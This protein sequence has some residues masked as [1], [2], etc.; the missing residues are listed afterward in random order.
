MGDPVFVRRMNRMVTP[1]KRPAW[2]KRALN[3][4]TPTTDARE[5]VRTTSVELDG[6]EALFPTVRMV[7]GK[8]KKYEGQE[9]RKEAFNIAMKKKDF[10]F[11]NTILFFIVPR[12][13]NKIDIIDTTSDTQR[14]NI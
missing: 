8:L 12:L 5:S 3:P 10:I 9:G 4:N 6:R 1:P 13:G 11:F 7:N 2:L 14:V